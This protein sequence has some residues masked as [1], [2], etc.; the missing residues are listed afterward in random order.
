MSKIEFTLNISKIM[1][2][3][4]SGDYTDVTVEALVALC[5]M[6][7]MSLCMSMRSSGVQDLVLG[8][9]TMDEY[10]E[11]IPD[12]FIGQLENGSMQFSVRDIKR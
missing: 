7:K 2:D 6:Y 9:H 3:A 4:N 8:K 12:L 10:E 11:N 1:Q 5:E